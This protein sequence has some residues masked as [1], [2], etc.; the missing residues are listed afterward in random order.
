[1]KNKTKQKKQGLKNRS[2][3]LC[4]YTASNRA[5]LHCDIKKQSLTELKKKKG[6]ERI[7][8]EENT[9]DFF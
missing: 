7:K 5:A 4:F 1:M 3:P 9:E 2:K 8:T 6:H